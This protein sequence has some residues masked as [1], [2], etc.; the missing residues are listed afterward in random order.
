MNSFVG[1]D[2]F[3]ISC[4]DFWEPS[5]V[6]VVNQVHYDLSVTKEEETKEDLTS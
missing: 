5:K 1:V 2:V 4:K 6:E 3:R